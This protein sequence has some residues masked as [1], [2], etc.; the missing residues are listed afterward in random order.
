MLGVFQE[1]HE[2]SVVRAA[3]TMEGEV[4]VGLGQDHGGPCGPSEALWLLP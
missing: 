3:R 2:A 4:K 1:S